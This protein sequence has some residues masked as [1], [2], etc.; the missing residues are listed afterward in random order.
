M[1]VFSVFTLLGGLAFFLYGIEVLS[2]GL[3]KLAG[4]KLESTLRRMTSNQFKGILLGAGITI[5]IQS[6]SAMTVMLVGL[7]NSGIMQLGQTI[8]VIMGSNIGTTL[9]AWILSLAGIE[10]DNFLI[11]LLKPESFSPILAFIGIALTT[12]S[13]KPR[14]RDVG[15]VLIGFAV[16]MFGMELMGGAVEP[17]RDMPEFSSLLVTF[18]NP[19]LGLLL[20]TVFTGIIQSSAATVGI[21]QALSLTGGISVGVAVPLVLG[22]NIGTCVTAIL[23]TI[24]VNKDAKRVSVI[25]LFI[26]IIGS[27]LFMAVFFSLKAFVPSFADFANSSANVLE[28]AV[29]HTIFNVFSVVLLLPFTKMLEKV[30][31]TLVRDK[32]G[33]SKKDDYVF[34]DERLLLSPSLAI[35]EC[36]EMTN[37]MAHISH[38]T[39]LMSLNCVREYD[40]NL[41]ELI[42]EKENIIDMYEDKLGSFLVK[43]S[44]KPLSLEDSKEISKLLHTINDFERIGDHAVN[45]LESAREMHQKEIAFSPQCTDELSIVMDALTEILDLSVHSFETNDIALAKHI[46]PLEQV[47]D[48]LKDVLRDRHIHRLQEGLCTIELGFVFTDLLT[49]FERVSDHCSNIAVCLIQ[50]ND[51]AFDIHDYL[52]NLK[53]SEQPSFS[54]EYGDFRQKY[55]LPEMRQAPVQE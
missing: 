36:K 17:L 47:I 41:D 1:N 18:S 27:V 44:S 21:I 22:A 42:V 24:G 51:A 34:L 39:L 30:A 45:I 26:N 46:E 28:V 43:L 19:L 13:K 2:G 35:A 32:K 38:D 12:F 7:V 10:S 3:N 4:G 48:D 6:S 33:E 23:S 52:N 40:A 11:N 25:H 31:Y 15:N 54:K 16:L 49:N 14:R 29:I 8:G 9:T 50:I 20:G 53:I 55:A 37:Q 5:A